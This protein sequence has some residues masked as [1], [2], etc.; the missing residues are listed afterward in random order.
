LSGNLV[1]HNNL[2]IFAP[3][4]ARDYGGGRNPDQQ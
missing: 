3:G 4:F 2:W 1:D